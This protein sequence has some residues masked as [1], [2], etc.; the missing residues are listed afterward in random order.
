MKTTQYKVGDWVE[1]YGKQHLIIGRPYIEDNDW[2]MNDVY[3]NQEKYHE[4]DITRK[5]VPSEVV[6]RIGCL[7]GTVEKAHGEYKGT[8]ILRGLSGQRNVLWLSMLDTTTRKLVESLLK[9][10]NKG[11]II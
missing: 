1:V 4:I 9:A 5:L 6:I 10:Q 3:G 8:F 7:S 11:D 2:L